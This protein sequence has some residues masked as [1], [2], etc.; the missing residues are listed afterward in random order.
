MKCLTGTKKFFLQTCGNLRR[1]QTINEVLRE[2][3]GSTKEIRN[4]MRLGN[5]CL[6]QATIYS[7][8]T[9]QLPQPQQLQQVKMNRNLF[10]IWK[11]VY[12]RWG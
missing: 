10:P 7:L 9:Q 1:A 12:L 8:K 6:A 2:F 3:S 5:S 4:R 11:K